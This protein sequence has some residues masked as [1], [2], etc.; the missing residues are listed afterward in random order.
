MCFPVCPDVFD[1]MHSL[2]RAVKIFTADLSLL[3]VRRT[4]IVSSCCLRI[5]MYPNDVPHFVYGIRNEAK[6]N[7]ATVSD[8]SITH[9]NK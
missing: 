4:G 1:V 9:I 5:C 6:K 7:Y 2:F 8:E 3:A